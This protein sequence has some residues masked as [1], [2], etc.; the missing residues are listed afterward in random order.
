MTVTQIVPAPRVNHPAAQAVDN[1][2]KGVTVLIAGHPGSWKSTWA[3]QWP[4]VVF[5]SIA[6]EGGD[7]SVKKDT[8]VPVIHSMLE[9]SQTPDC[10]P[11]FNA[12]PPTIF[13][14]K[15]TQQFKQYIKDITT[16][17]KQWGVCTVVIDS[18]TYLIDLWIRELIQH[19]SASDR[20]WINQVKKRGG[21]FLGPPEWGLLN[22]FLAQTRVDLGNIAVDGP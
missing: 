2:E 8:F 12:T 22:M 15:S 9:R 14:V 6:S 4:G 13:P 21:E 7:D 17:H 1:Y 16:N 5:L 18:L 19:K 20:N 11:S 10:P 3:A